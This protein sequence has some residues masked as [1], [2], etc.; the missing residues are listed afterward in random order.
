VTADDALKPGA[1]DA[2]PPDRPR[3]GRSGGQQSRG[4]PQTVADA[5]AA[6]DAKVDVEYRT[7]IVH[8]CCLETH[9]VCCD[10]RGGDTA[11]VY[12]STQGCHTIPGDAAKTLGL[13]QSNVT[14]I[15]ENMGGGFGSK[16]GIGIAATVGV[17]IVQAVERPG[18]DGPDAKG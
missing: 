4:N 8:H 6:C 15:V 18:E 7:K 9:S 5:I 16:F 12:A 1:Q 2:F 11:T 13:D 3:A 10:Y 17:Q 14:G